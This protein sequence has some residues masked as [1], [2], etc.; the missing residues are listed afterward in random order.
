MNLCSHYQ[1]LMYENTYKYILIFLQQF[2]TNNLK[3]LID[4]PLVLKNHY[5][6][7]R[8]ASILLPQLITVSISKLKVILL[9][10]RGLLT[11]LPTTENCLK[12][13]CDCVDGNIFILPSLLLYQIFLSVNID[14]LK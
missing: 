1:V 9:K 12:R 8:V 13:Q 10:T 6:K 7:D 14:F 11:A 4:F 5:Q 3:Y 2:N